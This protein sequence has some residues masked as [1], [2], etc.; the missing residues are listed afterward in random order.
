MTSSANLLASSA[1]SVVDITV[2]GAGPAGMAMAALAAADDGNRKVLL[3]DSSALE[4]R[5]KETRVLALSHGSKQILQQARLWDETIVRC[6]IERVHVSQRGR[7]GRTEVRASDLGSPALGYTVEYGALIASMAARLP[8]Q[9]HI[10]RPATAHL[11]GSSNTAGRI[12]QSLRVHQGEVSSQRN[13]CLLVRAEGGLFTE[14]DTKSFDTSHDY[15]QH[16][17]IARIAVKDQK[18]GTA[19]ERFTDEGPIALVPLETGHFSLVWCGSP[20]QTARRQHVTAQQLGAE[21]ALVYGERFTAASITFESDVRVYPLGLNWREDI[22]QGGIVTIGN[23]AQTLHPV[24][25]QGLNLALRDCVELVA[26]LRTPATQWPVQLTAW[27][28]RRKTDRRVTRGV[29]HA[30]AQFFATRF[31]P[32]QHLLGLGLLG[33]DALPPLRNWVG[34]QLMLGTRRVK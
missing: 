29:T 23:A 18:A 25:G 12:T 8:A 24:A 7:L 31:S 9:I 19:W 1:E 30:M 32:V 28:D 17:L 2:L 3:I 22:A 4:D 13:T 33:M 14:Q 6:A 26:A 21:L 5:V 11:L 15:Q 20:E 10:L 16:A 34:R 27:A